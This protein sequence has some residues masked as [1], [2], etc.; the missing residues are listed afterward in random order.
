M[1]SATVGTGGGNMTTPPAW[2]ATN[3]NPF[4][5][6]NGPLADLGVDMV[7]IYKDYVAYET[8]GAKGTF[9]SS[10]GSKIDYRGTSVGIQ[11]RGYGN[12]TTYVSALTALGMQVEGENAPTGTVAGLVP[13][14]DLIA[15]A[16]QAQTIG[17]GPI[18][19]TV[20]NFIGSA[21]NEAD[22]VEQANTAPLHL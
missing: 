6:E 21:H 14:S 18:Y 20:T 15:V 17:G 7:Q 8:A 12:L 10:L 1:L 9:V 2:H 16:T 19:P 3:T 5:A 13:L 22:D 11:L 4:D